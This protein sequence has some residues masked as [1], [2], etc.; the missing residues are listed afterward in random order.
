MKLLGYGVFSWGA[1]ERRTNRYGSF[2]MCG[3]SYKGEKPGKSPELTKELRRLDH[4]RV[5]LMAKV[6]ETRTS[7]H[8]GDMALR[9]SPTTPEVGQEILLG[10]GILQIESCSWDFLPSIA[11]V[12]KD[13]RTEMWIDPRIL[14]QLHDQTVEIYG[15][16]TEEDFH[17]APVIEYEAGAISLGED[18][19]QA[20]RI[21]AKSIQV[22]PKIEDK[23]KGTFILTK[24]FPAK[25][26]KMRK[27]NDGRITWEP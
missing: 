14:Y 10:V 2:N 25:G 6:I 3:E 26:T 27:A 5:K 16:E 15:E 21:D 18:G 9:I 12:P 24:Q 22:P 4:R 13:R 11:L 19:I 8:L 1:E 17:P 20:K 7:G 23:G